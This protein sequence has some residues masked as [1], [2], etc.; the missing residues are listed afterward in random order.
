MLQR[1]MKQVYRGINLELNHVI[2]NNY[3]SFARIWSNEHNNNNNSM[4]WGE[5]V[6]TTFNLLFAQFLCI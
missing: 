3:F 6:I 4:N 2:F 5:D 1:S